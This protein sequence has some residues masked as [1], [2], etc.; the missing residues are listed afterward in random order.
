MSKELKTKTTERIKPQA[1]QH[2]SVHARDKPL[3]NL[4]GS[5]IRNAGIKI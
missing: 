5:N 1:K 4:S 3:R 2:G